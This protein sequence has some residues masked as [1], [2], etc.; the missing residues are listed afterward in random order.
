M[1]LLIACGAL[2]LASGA[3]AQ[4]WKL[5]GDRET[6]GREAQAAILAHDDYPAVSGFTR[7]V[8]YIDFDSLSRR[9]SS[10]RTA[11]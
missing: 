9:R 10:M 4:P 8:D 5:P 1:R 3:A 7:R 11:R 2:A 6:L